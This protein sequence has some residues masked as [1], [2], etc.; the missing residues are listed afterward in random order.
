MD[1]Y[2]YIGLAIAVLMFFYSMRS[3]NRISREEAHK[4]VEDGAVLLDVRTPGEFKRDHLP[5]AK[6]IPLDALG[7]R[8][9]ELSKERALVVYCHSGM[10]SGRAVAVL[11]QAG[12]TAHDLGPISAW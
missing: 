11:T 1:T 6:N 9:S 4:L 3:R 8:L 2:V 12:F 10:R 5:N 7:K